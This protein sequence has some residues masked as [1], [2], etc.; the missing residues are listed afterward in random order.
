MMN[1]DKIAP[2]HVRLGY[3]LIPTLI[4]ALIGCGV[5]SCTGRGIA[6][7]ES[8]ALEPFQNQ[9]AEIGIRESL[10]DAI[11]DGLLSDRTL[12]IVDP[13]TADA[14]LYGTLTSVE[15]R[16]LSFDENE[17]VSEFEVRITVS[18]VLKKPDKAEAVWEGQITGAGSYPNKTGTIEERE[19]GIK[20]ALERLTQDLLNRL[21]SDW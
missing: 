7:I 2:V 1:T 4:V 18:F 6:G 9:T 17:A 20:L 19:E 14:I 15:D 5:Y 21:T 10:T 13:V 3:V 12:K 11:L 8:I 16:P